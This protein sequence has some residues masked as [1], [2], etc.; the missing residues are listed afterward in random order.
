MSDKASVPFLKIIFRTIIKKLLVKMFLTFTNESKTGFKNRKWNY[1]SYI[2]TSDRKNSFTKCFKL[3]SN[4]NPTWN[5]TEL[6]LVR[7][8]VDFVFKCHKNKKNK[9]PT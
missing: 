4:S 7:V 5:S 1:F 6:E 9:N 8:G 2:L 3:L